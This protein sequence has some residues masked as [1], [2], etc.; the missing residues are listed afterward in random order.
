MLIM[1]K[2][3]E[4]CFNVAT[5][6]KLGEWWIGGFLSTVAAFPILFSGRLLYDVSP[7]LFWWSILVLFILSFVSIYLALNV[8]SDEYP[9]VIVLDK[10]W[11]MI[12]A[13]AYIPL[14][15]KLI[16]F[17]FVLFHLINF[18]RPLLFCKTL[19]KKIDEL[20]FHLGVIVGDLVSGLICNLFLQLIVWIME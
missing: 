14:Q 11:G 4:I 5:F 12:V 10:V 3:K 20:P 6:G 13:F 1:N 17:G 18:L 2:I 19:G 15:W 9:S 7:N 16:L 8:I